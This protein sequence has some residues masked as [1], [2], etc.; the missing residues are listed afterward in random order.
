MLNDTK[1]NKVG[2][3][4]LERIW[5]IRDYIK[6]LE[7]VKDEF[8]EYI[9]SDDDID[10]STRSIWISNAKDFYFCTVTAWE[11]LHFT[12]RGIKNHLEDARGYLYMAKSKL[13]QSISEL[14]LL[15]NT[16]VDKLIDEVKKSFLKCEEAF[17]YNFALLESQTETKDSYPT[18]VKV[19]DKEYQLLC[20][21][22]GK[23]AV[24]FRIGK[25][26]FD[27]VD[28]LVIRGITYETSLNKKLAGELFKLVENADLNG[29]HGFM[30]KYH[31]YEGLDAYC[32]EC[33][34]IYCWIHYNPVEEWDEGFYDCTYGT[35]PIGHKRII[36]D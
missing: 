11:M 6:E 33:D 34:K 29:V 22:C 18:I 10:N 24:S 35:C 26:R 8:I 23:I 9:S 13:S 4:S 31:A 5:K 14:K 25:G 36:D 7:D 27:K 20:S 15:E 32:P 3:E 1:L 21:S 30:K 19:S 16:E 17:D 12:V 28:K 2:N